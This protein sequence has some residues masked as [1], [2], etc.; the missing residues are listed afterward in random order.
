[1]PSL[2]ANQLSVI[3][4][5]SDKG[6]KTVTEKFNTRTQMDINSQHILILKPQKIRDRQFF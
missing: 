6:G 3:L 5:C 1:M 4:P 2:S